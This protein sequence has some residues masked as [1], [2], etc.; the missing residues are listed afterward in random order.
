[1]TQNESARNPDIHEKKGRKIVVTVTNIIEAK[2][3]R[4]LTN[5]TLWDKIHKILVFLE[6]VSY[7]M[8][9]SHRIFKPRHFMKKLTTTTTTEKKRNSI[10]IQSF[11][12]QNKGFDFKIPYTSQISPQ[13][14]RQYTD[15][16]HEKQCLS[17]KLS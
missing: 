17:Y 2:C 4:T 13:T 16:K 15:E 6:P 7:W 1:M 8:L 5:R 14:S 10:V 11:Y 12:D 9:E 3:C